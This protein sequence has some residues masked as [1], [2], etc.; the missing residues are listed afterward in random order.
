MLVDILVEELH[1]SVNNNCVVTSEETC[2]APSVRYWAWT[3]TIW[4][5]ST[6]ATTLWW[7]GKGLWHGCQVHEQGHNGHYCGA[8]ALEEYEN[9]LGNPR[10]WKKKAKK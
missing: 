9:C 10:W 2:F 5:Y 6:L 1:M 3:D 7:F 4:Y 8:L